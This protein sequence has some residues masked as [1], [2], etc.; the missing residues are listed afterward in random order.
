[1]FQSYVFR[2]IGPSASRKRSSSAAW[3]PAIPGRV[4]AILRVAPFGNDFRPEAFR[5]EDLEADRLDA[6]AARDVT[7]GMRHSYCDATGSLYRRCIADLRRLYRLY[8]G[9]LE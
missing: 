5:R 4:C 8:R 9:P 1:M 2:F 3:R 6:A 7:F